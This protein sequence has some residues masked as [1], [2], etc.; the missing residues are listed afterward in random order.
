MNLKILRNNPRNFPKLK[1]KFFEIILKSFVNISWDFQKYFWKFSEIILEIFRNDLILKVFRNNSRNDLKYFS[2]I[3]ELFLEIILE[4][5]WHF[6]RNNTKLV[7]KIFSI[8]SIKSIFEYLSKPILNWNWKSYEWRYLINA[9][10]R[11]EY[12]KGQCLDHCCGISPSTT[13]WRR[14]SRRG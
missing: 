2:I 8:I 5:F 12:R 4:I 6:S 7:L 9:R 1:I 10:W 13:S 14:K 3:S 11:V